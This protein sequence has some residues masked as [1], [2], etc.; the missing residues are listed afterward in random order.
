MALYHTVNHMSAEKAQPLAR[1]ILITSHESTMAHSWCNLNSNTVPPASLLGATY[2][3]R[4]IKTEIPLLSFSVKYIPECITG[5]V[6]EVEITQLIHH[7][8]V[9]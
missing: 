3:E 6:P 9:T 4:K 5:P 7:K 2:Q 1:R 8:N